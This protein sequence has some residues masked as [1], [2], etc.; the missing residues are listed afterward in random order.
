MINFLKELFKKLE[1]MEIEKKE[2]E[3]YLHKF[4]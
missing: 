2:K 4:Q 3:F 1:K